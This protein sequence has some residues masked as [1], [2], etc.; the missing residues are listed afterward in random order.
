MTMGTVLTTMDTYRTWMVD[1]ASA[2]LVIAPPIFYMTSGEAMT[3]TLRR[4]IWSGCI[5]CFPK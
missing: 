3:S 4:N 5:S 2:L 1:T